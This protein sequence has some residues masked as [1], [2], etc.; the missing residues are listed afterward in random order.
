MKT[1][2]L[3]YSLPFAMIVLS[4]YIICITS[5]HKALRSISESNYWLQWPYRWTF[6]VVMFFTSACILYISFFLRSS[7]VVTLLL[8]GICLAGVGIFS[9]FKKDL[10]TK[11]L[12][13]LSAIGTFTF[14]ILSFI[15]VFDSINSLLIQLFA[16][17][18]AL[19]RSL[20]KEKSNWA[21]DKEK[22]IW[23]CEVFLIY[24]NVSCLFP[25]VILEV[26]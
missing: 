18:I 7:V 6:E 5:K 13:W 25:L 14:L 8:S 12:H 15:I 4:F 3:I 2:M 9:R 16:I 20:H 10:C 24:S 22:I 17:S 11:I 19:Y 26:L 23:N 21:I 1:L